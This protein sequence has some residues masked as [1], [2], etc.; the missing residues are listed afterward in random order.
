MTEII[1]VTIG[2]KLLKTLRYLN[3]L[4]IASNMTKM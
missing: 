2:L 3:V 1:I 4:R